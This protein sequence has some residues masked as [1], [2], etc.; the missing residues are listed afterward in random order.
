VL[1]D[2]GAEQ[3][4]ESDAAASKQDAKRSEAA[5]TRLLGHWKRRR[6]SVDAVAQDSARVVRLRSGPERADEEGTH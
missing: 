3:Q 2:A 1:V 6:C 5:T 4:T